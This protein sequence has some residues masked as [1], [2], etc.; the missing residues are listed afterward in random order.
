M[1][2]EKVNFYNNTFIQ[3]LSSMLVVLHW[4][5]SKTNN[6]PNSY[7]QQN[8]KKNSYTRTMSSP[9]SET[10]MYKRGTSSHTTAQM[11]IVICVYTQ[12]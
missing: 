11:L 5:Q 4:C 8:T 12:S 6:K 3:H 7:T 2:F 9:Q 1:G 10:E